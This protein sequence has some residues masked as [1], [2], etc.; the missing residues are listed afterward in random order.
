MEG[1]WQLCSSRL[2][3]Y[4]RLRLKT[5]RVLLTLKYDLKVFIVVRYRFPIGCCAAHLQALSFPP[6]RR[7]SSVFHKVIWFL[8][9]LLSVPSWL[10]HLYAR[11]ISMMSSET[12]K[13]K[14]SLAYRLITVLALH[15]TALPLWETIKYQIYFI[16]KSLSIIMKK[17]PLSWGDLSSWIFNLSIV[18]TDYR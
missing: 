1:V 4:S 13:V 11:L 18:G 16:K 6:F 12:L 2:P 15:W 9:F 17:N 14:L 7:I 3:G 5:K 10:Q 8:C